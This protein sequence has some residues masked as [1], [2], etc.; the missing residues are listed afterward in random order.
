M[1]ASLL[2]P[3]SFE[4]PNKQRQIQDAKDMY[5]TVVRNAER[6]NS[7]APPYTFIELIGKGGYGRVYKCLEQATGQ[8]VAV[9]IINIDDADFQEHFLDKDNTIASFRKEVEILQQLKDNKAKNVN[10]IHT[11]FDLHNQLWIVSDYCTGG[12]LR[13]LMRANPPPRRGF[14]E[15]FL[16]PIARELA[17]AIKSVHDIGVIHRDI[18]CANVYVNE[19]GDIQLGDFGIVGVVDDGSSKRRTIVGTPHYLPREMHL[20]S[21]HL[22]DEA[23]GT[24]VDIWS[25]GITMFEAATGLPPYANVP[26]SQFH[27]VVDNPPR[28]EGDDYSDELKAFIAYCLDSDPK[29]RPSAAEVLTH[30]YI[31]DSSKR[32]PTRGLVRLIERYAGWEY[33][34]GQ[35]QSLWAPGGAMGPVVSSGDDS[36][37][38][39]QSDSEDWNFSTSDNFNEAFGR[40]YSQMVSAQDFANP[41]FDA[42][43][44]SGLPPLITKDLTP[45]ERFEQEFKE[46]SANR[47]ERSLDRLFNPET[48]PYELHTPVEDTEPMSDLPFRNM[49]STAP[50]RESVIDLDHA[51]GL[52][53]NVPTF[54]FDFGDVPTLKARTSRP[55]VGDD[56]EEQDHQHNLNERDERRATMD[57]TF[58]AAAE[59]KRAT[60]DWSFQSAGTVEPEDPNTAMNLPSKASEGLSHGFRPTLKHTATEPVGN[61]K[62]FTYPPRPSAPTEPSPV[63]QS[64]ASM[65]DL[66]MGLADPADIERPSTASSATGST[67]TDMTSGN[68][69][70]LEDNPEQNEVDRNRFSYHKQWQSEGGQPKRLSHKTMPMHSRG[71]SLSGATD[72][73]LDRTTGEPAPTSDVFDYEYGREGFQDEYRTHMFAGMPQY[74]IGHWPNFGSN[75]G[76]DESPKYPS[77][78]TPRLADPDFP[79]QQGLRTNG[80]P[81]PSSMRLRN[82]N[83]VRRPQREI[84]FV[85]PVAPHPD[86]L[87]EDANPELVMS[88]LERLLE[89]FDQ[90]LEATARALGQHTGVETESESS[91]AESG[92]ESSGAVTTGDEDGF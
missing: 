1:A 40:R 41:H 63:R 60:M 62:N 64:V 49:A 19:E 79:V 29:S 31:A 68:P 56:D 24:E 37:N 6:S 83:R 88:E 53:V 86:A 9:K 44:G 35:R 43:A 61:S 73:E 84:E 34:G 69:F 5:Q 13:T 52:D 77:T 54:N 18:K 75:S 17:T 32:Y 20:S 74:D 89:D 59:K 47:G 14:E 27:T 2:A 15:H 87:L 80:L 57:W 12:S 78:Y 72:L 45:F 7:A 82:G 90:N 39:I 46:K 81:N 23:Y 76:L 38:Q 91:E 66:D 85:D 71:S 50:A 26:Q 21:S 30:P 22:T 70:D 11:A 33:K 48:A 28:L 3:G 36:D 10:M 65:I 67:A 51:T 25:Y 16:L 8:L 55:T 4:A 42:P 92:R 58:P